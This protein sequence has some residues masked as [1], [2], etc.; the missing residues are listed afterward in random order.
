MGPAKKNDGARNQW[1]QRGARHVIYWGTRGP[2]RRIGAESSCLTCPPIS[3][4]PEKQSF[5]NE[6]ASAM[7]NRPPAIRSSPGVDLKISQLAQ[8]QDPVPEVYSPESI[9]ALL[10]STNMRV[11][12]PYGQHELDGVGVDLVANVLNPTDAYGF[13]PKT[14]GHIELKRAKGWGEIRFGVV[15]LHHPGDP[16][17]TFREQDH[18]TPYVAIKML[19]KRVVNDYLAG[20]GRENPYKEICRYQE[21][22]DNVHVIRFEALEDCEKLYVIT[23]KGTPFDHV[24]F[25]PAQH[26]PA[27]IHEYVV[28]MLSILAYLEQHN[29]HHRDLSPD[30][31]LI[32]P[33]G[34]LVL[35]DFAMS[36][37]IPRVASV[38]GQTRRAMFTNQ[39]SFGTRSWMAPE[40]FNEE[41][42]DGVLADLWCVMHIMYN[43]ETK[44]LLLRIPHWLDFSYRFFILAGAGG[45]TRGGA[46]S[47]MQALEEIREEGGS[48]TQNEIISLTVAHR[49]LPLNVRTLFYNSFANNPL[50]RWTLGQVIR[51][52][53]VVNG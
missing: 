32:L 18:E 39:G 13:L 25:G 11:L 21:L 16:P 50:E 2:H 51:S 27:T 34:E 48:R 4:Q 53:Y 6:L 7:A 14:K 22:G 5:G 30:N 44:R 33:N 23:P 45:F 47:V 15:F 12:D 36:L 37:R 20:G 52:D 31:L 43:L 29:I 40:I 26:H 49:N 24:V 35:F 10:K 8:P 3:P 42:F 41:S 1:N 28:Q 46:G 9:P 17:N 19:N 38:D